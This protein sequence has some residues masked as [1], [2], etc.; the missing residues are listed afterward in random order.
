MIP[1]ET[2]MYG[3]V[4][5]SAAA[6]AATCYPLVA[7]LGRRAVTK[8]EVYQRVKVRQATK[9]LDDIF[10]EV[11]PKWLK[12]AYGLGPLLAGLAAFILFESVFLACVGAVLGIV[13]PDI[14]MRQTQ[15]RRKRRFEAQLLDALF[16]LSS[17]LR[18]GLSL[19]QA[20]EVLEAEMPPP[21]SQEF[22]LVVKAV[23]LGRTFDEALQSLNQRMPSDAM[24]LMTT[25]ILVARETGGDVTNVINQLILTIRERKKLTDKVQTLTLQG[26]L[27]AY[28]MS[29]LPVGF[30]M[31]VR[32]F[33]PRYFDILLQDAVGVML[34]ATAVG[35]WLV[36]MLLLIKLSRVEV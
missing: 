13:L 34:L 27:Q 12:T 9:V 17:S 24:N 1:Q 31:F 26:R 28:I 14:W 25:A 33:N 18:A 22:G 15:A 3:L 29:I 30:A 11:K 7:R 23:R 10:V 8:M 20:I 19:T 4:M 36:G 5:G 32:G 35:L 6:A 16:I 2:L 21:A